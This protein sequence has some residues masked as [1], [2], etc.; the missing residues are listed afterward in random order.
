[1]VNKGSKLRSLFG[2]NIGIIQ[3]NCI[4]AYLSHVMRKPAFAYAKTEAQIR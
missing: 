1:M 2:N 3:E 4:R